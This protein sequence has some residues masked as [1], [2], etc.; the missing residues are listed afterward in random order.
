MLKV[1]QQY[2]TDWGVFH[3]TTETVCDILSLIYLAS[4]DITYVGRISHM[5][6]LKLY[7]A[8]DS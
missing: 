4:V 1:K 7:M 3:M 5:T 6:H 2:R 8:H